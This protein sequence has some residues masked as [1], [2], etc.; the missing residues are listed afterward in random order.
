[1]GGGGE[2]SVEKYISLKFDIC[3]HLLQKKYLLILFFFLIYRLIN[4]EGKFNPN[5]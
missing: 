5:L 2:N 3:L 4:F 1:M